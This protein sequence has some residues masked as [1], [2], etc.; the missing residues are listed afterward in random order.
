MNQNIGEKF[1][2][3]QIGTKSPVKA[4]LIEIQEEDEDEGP[5]VFLTENEDKLYCYPEEVLNLL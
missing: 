1:L 4:K 3:Q 5:L 2:I